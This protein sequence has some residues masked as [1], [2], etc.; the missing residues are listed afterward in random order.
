MPVLKSR[1]WVEV[2]S[3][4]TRMGRGI[5][6][7]RR[8]EREERRDGSGQNSPTARLTRQVTSNLSVRSPGGLERSFPKSEKAPPA[9]EDRMEDGR[10]RMEKSSHV[11]SIPY[12]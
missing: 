10:S 1:Q 3:R 7:G 2:H 8:A 6:R 11:L 4:N 9:L 5:F 12:L